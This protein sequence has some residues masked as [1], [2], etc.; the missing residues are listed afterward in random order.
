M[1]E[2]MSRT[3]AR[4]IALHMIF[5]EVFAGYGDGFEEFFLSEDN[6]ASLAEEHKLYRT[7]PDE[8]QRL[9]ICRLYSG[10]CGHMSELDTYIEKYARG[11]QFGRISRPAIA[12]LRLSMYEILYM[13]DIPNGASINECVD[14]SREYDCEEASAFVNGVLSAFLR[15]EY[16]ALHV[17]RNG[18]EPE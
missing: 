1:N 14:F 8:I 11:W 10:V 13:E 4:E 5:A 16:E 17:P 7:L 9:Y 12:I 18:V 2:Q 6:F 15:N 3:V